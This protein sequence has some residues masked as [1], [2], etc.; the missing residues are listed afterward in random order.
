MVPKAPPDAERA[1]EKQ[2]LLLLENPRHPSLRTKKYDESV[3][4]W[5][6]RVTRGWRFYFAIE[7]DT[8]RMLEIKAHPK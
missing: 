7:G 1:F 6:A 2:A 3:G 5:Q 4:L 8:C